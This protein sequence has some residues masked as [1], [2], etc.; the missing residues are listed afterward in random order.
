MLNKEGN[1]ILHVH[2]YL[3]DIFKIQLWGHFMS[4]TTK[5]E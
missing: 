2:I 4:K 1:Y 3:D 5:E